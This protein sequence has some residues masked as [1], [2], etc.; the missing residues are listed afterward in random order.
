M[1]K[2]IK[3]F[4]GIGAPPEGYVI[5]RNGNGLWRW[6]TKYNTG[7]LCFT[8]AGAIRSARSMHYDDE[9][10]TRNTTWTIEK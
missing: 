10:V 3:Y 1:I 5:Q 8:R 4:L 9:S 6:M 2:K 7:E